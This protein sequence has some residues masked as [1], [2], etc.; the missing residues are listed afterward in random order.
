M[1][2]DPKVRD[3]YNERALR[4]RLTADNCIRHLSRAAERLDLTPEEVVG[5]ARTKPDRLRALL[6]RTAAAL[7][8]E[9]RL[10]SYIAKWF[11]AVKSYL[12]FRRVNVDVFPRLSSVAGESLANE[13]VPTP[14]QLGRVLERLSLRGRVVALL[15]AHA[16]VRPGV[17]GAYQGEGGLRLRDL[18]DLKLGKELT[19]AEVPFVVRIPA[20]ISKTRTA[21]T[22]FGTSQLATALLAYLDSR[23]ERGEELSPD[24][25]VVVA[26]VSR[27]IAA[28]SLEGAKF[29]RGFLTT[30]AVVEELHQALKATVPDGGRWRPYCLRAYASSRLLV[31]EGS[32][33]MTRD[34]RE[35]ILGHSLGVSGRYNLGKTWGP[36]TLKEAR[37]SYRRAAPYLETNASGTSTDEATAKALRLIA[38]SKG[39][40]PEQLEGLDLSGKSEEETVAFLR[41][42]GFSAAAPEPPREE[43]VPVA[44]IPGR[45]AAGW[46]TVTRLNDSMAVLRAPPAPM[47]APTI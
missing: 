6:T 22:S 32:G 7:K 16:G 38:L 40:P 24:S 1:A 18:P 9:G 43:A 45:L 46:T 20:T 12:R 3:W 25:P 34:L 23:R 44:E 10:D 21:Y 35:A 13:I 14:E 29:R 15:M 42:I 39:I 11:E 30:K 19:F 41:K 28:Q 17:I 4:S 27:G 33:K 26:E 37:A 8:S 5:M 31:A 36:E 47:G 2:K